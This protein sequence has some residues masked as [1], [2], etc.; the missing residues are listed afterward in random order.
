MCERCKEEEIQSKSLWQEYRKV[1]GI[2]EETKK[3]QER[4]RVKFYR[5]KKIYEKIEKEKIERDQLSKNFLDGYMEG[6]ME[7]A[8]LDIDTKF[9][10]NFLYEKN[11]LKK[12]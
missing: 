5:V 4:L 1:R 9:I 12:I 3:E 11:Y 6:Y 2:W 7:G 8:R 10:L